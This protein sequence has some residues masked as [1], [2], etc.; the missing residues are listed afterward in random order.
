MCKENDRIERLFS[1]GQEPKPYSVDDILSACF[2]WI[3]FYCLLLL[4]EN[5][6]LSRS[7]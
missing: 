1:G 5:V 4:E 2:G 7:M 6:L 3:I